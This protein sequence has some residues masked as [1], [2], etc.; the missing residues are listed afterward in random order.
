VLQFRNRIAVSIENFMLELF[1]DEYK[2]GFLIM[3][4]QGSPFLRDQLEIKVF[5]AQPMQVST[6][7]MLMFPLGRW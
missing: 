7:N 4:L 6:A 2:I 5:E 1:L 3:L